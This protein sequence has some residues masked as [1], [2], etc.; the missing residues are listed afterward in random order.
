MRTSKDFTHVLKVSNEFLGNFYHILRSSR[1]V[2]ET[3]KKMKHEKSNMHPRSM[4]YME[5]NNKTFLHI[6][7]IILI[8][9]YCWRSNSYFHSFWFVDSNVVFL[10]ACAM[11]TWFK[12]SKA[13]IWCKNWKRIKHSH[14]CFGISI[15]NPFAQL[16]IVQQ[17]FNSKFLLHCILYNVHCAPTRWIDSRFSVWVTSHL[18]TTSHHNN[19]IKEWEQDGIELCPFL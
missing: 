1:K 18:R 2:Q 11:Y 13:V 7:T 4:W 14:A 16:Y 15:E 9:F 5:I 8:I 6:V 12:W 3:I 10:L 19:I 17:H